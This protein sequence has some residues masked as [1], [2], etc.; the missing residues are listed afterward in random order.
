MV[1]GHIKY[2]NRGAIFYN[3]KTYSLS[4]LKLSKCVQKDGSDMYTKLDDGVILCKMINLAS[5]DTI[6]ERVLNK[7]VTIPIFKVG[8]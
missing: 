5:A 6:D 7:G 1:F 3:R 8:L 4:T 2:Y